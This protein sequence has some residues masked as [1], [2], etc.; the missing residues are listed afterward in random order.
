MNTIPLK[1]CLYPGCTHKFPEHYFASVCA[2]HPD[3]VVRLSG[4]VPPSPIKQ[5]R[6]AWL[7]SLLGTDE[8]CIGLPGYR[9]KLVEPTGRVFGTASEWNAVFSDDY[10]PDVIYRVTYHRDC[11]EP[12]A[13][14]DGDMVDCVQ[15]FRHT[16]IT[17]EENP[18]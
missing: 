11:P 8:R 6:K 7:A 18:E 15:V 9:L 2:A 10:D 17:Y 3:V 1:T 5:F 16:T 12:F 14:L 13:H 4:K